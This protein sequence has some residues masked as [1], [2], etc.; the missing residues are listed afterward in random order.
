MEAPP[1]FLDYTHH[2][3]VEGFLSDRVWDTPVY[4]YIYWAASPP[5]KTSY[6]KEF[7]FNTSR[8]NILSLSLD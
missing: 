5:T 1:N 7:I 3:R 4:L 2:V 8:V 6:E